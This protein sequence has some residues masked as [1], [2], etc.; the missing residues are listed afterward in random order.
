VSTFILPFQNILKT[1]AFL[2]KIKTRKYTGHVPPMSHPPKHESYLK[3][4]ADNKRTE[5]YAYI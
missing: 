2:T 4:L 1:L 5:N 3:Y